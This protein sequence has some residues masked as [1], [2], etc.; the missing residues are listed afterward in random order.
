MKRNLELVIISDVHLGSPSCHAK[1]LLQYLRSI[2]PRTLIINGDFID[3]RQFRKKHF[4][5]EHQEVISEVIRMSVSK[6]K[7]YYLMGNHD[8]VLRKRSGFSPGNI[9]LMNKMSFK[10]K[11]KT[12]W[13]FHGDV[14]DASIKFSP[15]IVRLGVKG[16]ELL[17]NINRVINRVRKIFGHPRMSFSEKVKYNMKRALQ[18]INAFEKAAV[19]LAF[20]KEYDYVIC[21]HIHQPGI[22][23]VEGAEHTVTYMNAG[24]WVEHLTALEYNFGRW[25]LHQYDPDDFSIINKRL[26]VKPIKK[27]PTPI[28]RTEE[29]IEEFIHR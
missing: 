26:I 24:D 14:F 6:T 25:E 21:G 11:E 15:Y 8:D 5:A 17:L 3:S 20:E 28:K 23:K 19:N 1:E 4:L 16:Y 18:Y 13:V 22:K 27:K 2:K 9:K 29:L 7:V 12:Y 10:L